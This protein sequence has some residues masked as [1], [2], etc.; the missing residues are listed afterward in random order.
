M[1]EYTYNEHCSSSRVSDVKSQVAF[2]LAAGV[3]CNAYA[4]FDKESLIKESLSS[5]RDLGSA[6]L[7][8]G[9][10]LLR[11]DTVDPSN[12]YVPKTP[13]GN[14]LLSLRKK[15]I[16]KGMTLVTAKEVAAEIE[17]RR[18]GVNV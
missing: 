17:S 18:G 6:K 1:I 11:G 12:S 16:E 5:V 7:I 3:L 15:A 8:L 2:L 10:D 13:F 14:M 9:S 4:N